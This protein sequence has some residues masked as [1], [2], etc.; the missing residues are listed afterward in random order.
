M[1]FAAGHKLAH[2]ELIGLIGQGGMGEV[3]RARDGK[4][5]RDVAIKV[6]PSEFSDNPDRLA[7]F[8]R[9]AKVL[10]SLNH[11]NIASIYGFQE[12][13]NRRFLVLELVE[14]ED[15]S[16]RLELGPV[17]INEAIQIAGQIAEALEEAHEK[18]IVHRDLK[19]GNVKLTPDGRIKVLDFG[20]A[21]AWT[22][23][24]GSGVAAD[25]SQSPTITRMGTQAGVIL[26]T[27]RYMSPEQAR[28]K[29]V[30][31]RT[32]VWAFGVV[33][34]EMLTG[35]EL[36]TGETVTDALAAVL[37][38]EIDLGALPVATQPPIRRLL[39]RCLE[40]NPKNRLHDI[41][42]A[43][44]VIDEVLSG[45]SEES[46]P[47]AL[48]RRSGV[49][50]TLPLAAAALAAVLG[51]LLV[52]ATRPDRL[53][54][55]PVRTRRLTLSGHDQQPSVSPDGRF[56]AFA[57]TRDGVS[58]IW[59]KQI[60][61][62]GEQRLTEG[63]DFR[64]RFAPDG[65]SVGFLHED[66]PGR[67]DLYRTALLGGQ[68]GR[69][70]SNV[71]DFDWSPDGR[72]VAFTRQLNDVGREEVWILGVVEV[73]DAARERT[74]LEL[75]GWILLGP[76][77]R[78][79]GGRIAVTRGGLSNSSGGWRLLLVDPT[80]GASEDLAASDGFGMISNSAWD[81][82]G[83]GLLFAASPNNIGDLTGAP[84]A[85]RLLV[86]GAAP[87]TLF[88]SSGLFPQGGLPPQP[89]VFSILGSNRLIFDAF[90]QSQEL[91]EVD[92]VNGATRQLTRTLA[93][94]RQP[95]YSP[96]GRFVVFSSNRT[97]NLDI[98]LLDRE[99]RVLRQ[100]TDD[101]SQDW[102]P[103]FTADGR[104]VL[105][106]SSRGGN[107]EI[108]SI[109]LDG[110][111]ARQLSDD[112]VN[113]ENPTMTAEG[114][115]V[116]YSSGNPDHPGLY[117]VRSDGSEVSRITTGSHTTPEVSPDGRWAL[118]V[119]TTGFSARVQFVEIET[120]RLAS[121]A[122]DL[123]S[124][125]RT[126]S[127]SLGRGRWTRKGAALAY[128]GIDDRGRTGI[129]EQDFDPDH[130]TSAT[131]RPLAGFFDDMQTE[132]FGVAPDGSTVT[133]AVIRETRSLMLA[134]GLPDVPP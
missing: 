33:L 126:T 125:M 45:R 132:S 77:W 103:G 92:L 93:T 4:L 106:S 74:L 80:T 128:A 59:L 134:E 104:R 5:G 127:I 72:S 83:I 75:K 49:R 10:A 66:E 7:R 118:F 2:Y 73:D 90:E 36:F 62:G 70:V 129:F 13:D 42:D 71:N 9:E 47:G 25:L 69:L 84:A 46:A 113:A 68:P 57:S 116:V 97:G 32:D 54:P 76:R 3:Y 119:S 120:G 23:D 85:V 24:P 30:D 51:A 20:L 31:K 6:L 16:Q 60:E 95:A 52:L 88:W 18:G 38:T 22:V 56:V 124:T 101:A 34:F 55:E 96:D 58:Q 15:L 123:G 43:R 112:G 91:R 79:D 14:G 39:R 100:L 87:R 21:K 99:S 19:P 110:S 81:H 133:L 8:E 131:R 28:G 35:R 65:N 11:P 82:R 50:F 102:D 111:N 44:I 107:L 29:S 117:R 53:P 64:P 109:D 114:H 67:Y 130:D 61:V 86:P 26:G 27:A 1:S 115:W 12:A 78:P 40:R 94:D 63:A 89:T 121:A 37:T 122:I 41:A 105:F 17:P 48:A 108:W 98:W